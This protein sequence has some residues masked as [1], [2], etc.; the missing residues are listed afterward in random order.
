MRTP[1]A[2]GY[3]KRIMY[4]I[5]GIGVLALALFAAGRLNDA[6]PN[7]PAPAIAMLVLCLGVL[8]LLVMNW[9]RRF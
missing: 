7:N 5:F 1:R 9:N 4:L 8:S 2:S 3:A 6:N